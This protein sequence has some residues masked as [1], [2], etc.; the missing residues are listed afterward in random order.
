[1]E[2]RQEDPEFEVSL[3]YTV[4]PCPQTTKNAHFKSPKK[5]T[6]ETKFS[7]YLQTSKISFTFQPRSL[8][9][10]IPGPL[11]IFCPMSHLYLPPSSFI[12]LLKLSWTSM[13]SASLLSYSIA[14]SSSWSP[15]HRFLH[16]VSSAIATW[17][18]ATEEGFPK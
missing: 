2:L 10:A 13:S 14:E 6:F 7:V 11:H 4:R 8:F 1:L 3:G 12:L 17:I 15:R 16:L 18:I 5:I 9:V